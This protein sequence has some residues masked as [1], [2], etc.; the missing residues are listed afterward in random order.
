MEWLN[1]RRPNSLVFSKVVKPCQECPFLESGSIWWGP[2][3]AFLVSETPL[4]TWIRLKSSCT[5]ES[6]SQ[7]LDL[8]P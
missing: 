1:P 5:A 7:G 4:Q 6:I 8:Q 3:L 2:F